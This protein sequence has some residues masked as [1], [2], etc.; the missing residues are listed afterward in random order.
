MAV[1]AH[2]GPALAA[3]GA[4]VRHLD[5]VGGRPDGDDLV[6]VV[7]VP[8]EPHERSREVDEVA[9]VDDPRPTERV[10]L[11]LLRQL[12]IVR[13]GS[14]DV[15]REI[16][17]GVQRAAPAR[18]RP[19]VRESEAPRRVVVLLRVRHVDRGQMRPELPAPGEADRLPLVVVRGQRKAAGCRR[20][21]RSGR[22]HVHGWIAARRRRA[23]DRVVAEKEVERTP[24]V[25]EVVVDVDERVDDLRPSVRL[26]VEEQPR[27]DLRLCARAVR[28]ERPRPRE[29]GKTGLE[30]SFG[31]D[32]SRDARRAQLQP[33]PPPAA[34]PLPAAPSLLAWMCSRRTWVILSPS[35]FMI[36]SAR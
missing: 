28:R 13:D 31:H 6:W 25:A 16:R 3:V 29:A 11:L 27:V 9:L 19:R 24:R 12:E 15:A 34:P 2:D 35:R 17:A 26:L 5:E 7:E 20:V 1:L 10:A 23:R 36:G 8:R 18:K 14:D 21:A 30:R 33:Q 22:R 32:A 4:M